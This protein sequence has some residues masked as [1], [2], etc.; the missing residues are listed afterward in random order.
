MYKV[1]KY[2]EISENFGNTYPFYVEI[3]LKHVT[4]S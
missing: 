3:I 1:L 4:F 2:T